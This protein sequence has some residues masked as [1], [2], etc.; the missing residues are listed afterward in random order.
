M[1]RKNFKIFFTRKTIKRGKKMT[2]S[3][4]LRTSQKEEFLDLTPK[5]QELVEKSE[6]KNGLVLVYVPHTTCGL[7]INEHADPDVSA[8][9]LM[10]LKRAVPDNLSYSHAEG[11]SPAHIK[12]SLLG[13]SQTIFVENG[14]LKLGTWQG[15]FLCEFDGPR[16]RQVWVKI[17]AD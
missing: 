10:A 17:I 7:T 15:L 4:S 13:S 1:S 2:Y 16:T 3:L 8:D 9:I 12:A 5:I 6:I 14:R 11:N